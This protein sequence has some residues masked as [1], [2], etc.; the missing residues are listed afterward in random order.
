MSDII[1][2]VTTDPLVSQAPQSAETT[3]NAQ[4]SNNNYIERNIISPYAAIRN[5]QPMGLVI[6]IPLPFETDTPRPIFG[7]KIQPNSPM[8]TRILQDSTQAWGSRRVLHW[9]YQKNWIAPTPLDW[10]DGGFQNM[11]IGIIEQDTEPDI[12]LMSE[13]A[14]GWTGGLD[15]MIQCVSNV[16]TQGKIAITRTYNNVELVDAPSGSS[17]NYYGRTT[18]VVGLSQSA[19]QRFKNCGQIVD[20]SRQQDIII[21]CPYRHALPYMP[22]NDM[23]ELSTSTKTRPYGQPF[24]ALWFD[25]IGPLAASAGADELLLVPYI[26]AREDF[27]F[28][29]SQPPSNMVRTFTPRPDD[30]GLTDPLVFGK[31]TNIASMTYN[32]I[33]LN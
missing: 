20:F 29:L 16:T 25:N 33:T 24:N 26:R 12:S 3:A 7:L 11:D 19:T 2:P 6:R 14:I 21:E 5:W 27:Q 32:T 4:K 1:T 13:Y 18:R 23:V 31:N 10:R 17:L 22:I 9:G 8:L 28:I 15:F 30:F